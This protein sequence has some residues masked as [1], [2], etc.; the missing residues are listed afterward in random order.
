MYSSCDTIVQLQYLRIV[1]R[2][3]DEAIVVYEIAFN[4]LIWAR[5]V[6]YSDKSPLNFL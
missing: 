2:D 5:K 1:F 3:Q 6:E 4:V